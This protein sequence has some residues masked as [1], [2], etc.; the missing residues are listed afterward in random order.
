MFSIWMRIDIITCCP[1]LFESPLRHF[2]FQRAM[3]QQLLS[4]CIHNLRDYTPCKHGKIDDQPYGGAAGMLLMVEP[5]ANCIRALQKERIYDEVI[6]MAPDG[7]PLDQD[8]VNKCS[9]KQHLILLCG[10]YKGI[11][12]RIREHFITL[13]ISIGD[14]VLSGGELPALILADAMVRV[15]PGVISDA[16][17]ALTDSFQDGLVAPPAYTR[18]YNFEGKKVPD[19]LCSGNHKAIQEWM[20][21]KT[22]ARTKKRR[23]HLLKN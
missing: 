12:E 5:I 11:D 10:H 14:Y 2:I 22:V 1:Q 8:L 7:Q 6:Y 4:I 9:L 18:P 15:I 19:V 17:S 3:Q 16:S 13:E 21:R 20:Q 23:P